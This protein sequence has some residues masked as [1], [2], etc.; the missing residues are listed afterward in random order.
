MQTY[1]GAESMSLAM[2][3][4]ALS[5]VGEGDTFTRE[6]YAIFIEGKLCLALGK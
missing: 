2:S 6:I 5:G 1:R 4:S 3:H